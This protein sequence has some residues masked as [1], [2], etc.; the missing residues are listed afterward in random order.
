MR[1]LISQIYAR[2]RRGFL[3]GFLALISI[4][5][6]A[7]AGRWGR[8]LGRW[9]WALLH[10]ERQLA[11][12]QLSH[13]DPAISPMTRR[14]LARSNFLHLGEVLMT[15][16]SLSARSGG[17]PILDDARRGILIENREDFLERVSDLCQQ[18]GVVGIS[19]HLGAWELAA[20][21]TGCAGYPVLAK[22]YPDPV[23][24]A[25][26]EGI[27]Q[28]LGIRLI[29]QDQ[30]LMR[31]IRHLKSREMVSMLVDLDIRAMDGV[32]VPLLGESAHTTAAPARLA[33]KTDSVLWPYFLIRGVGG[34]YRFEWEDP[35][36]I[37][38]LDPQLSE[39][40]R[41]M[42]LTR[43]MNSAIERAIRRHP[44]QWVWMHR[45]WRSTPEVIRER[46]ARE[47]AELTGNGSTR[48]A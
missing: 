36:R 1:K 24:Q 31:V 46:K 44:E 37:D 8:V 9:G 30:S 45:R 42:E 20:A 27:R 26:V 40:E 47:Q 10:R 28:R 34:S 39:E 29:Y 48:G 6:P 38:D 11:M 33:L 13:L 2:F 3:R 22:R 4:P 43:K 7:A 21:T 18:G 25:L 14:S 23:E 16:C 5:A 12:R 17:V 32:H 15:G 19:A 41:I 35:I